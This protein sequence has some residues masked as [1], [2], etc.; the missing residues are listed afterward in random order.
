MTDQA[1]AILLASAFTFGCAAI[2]KY[3]EQA[4]HL[5][6]VL[7]GITTGLALLSVMVALAQIGSEGPVYNIE[8]AQHLV[9][10]QTVSE[11]HQIKMAE[12]RKNPGIKLVSGAE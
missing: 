3:R 12:A 2:H 8:P 1:F 6:P 5:T 10:A 4:Q 7:L 11:R 9:H